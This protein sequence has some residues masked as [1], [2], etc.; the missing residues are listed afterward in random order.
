[1]AF[2]LLFD[3]IDPQLHG[4]DVNAFSSFGDA[5]VEITNNVYKHLGC[6]SFLFCPTGNFSLCYFDYKWF[7]WNSVFEYMPIVIGEKFHIICLCIVQFSLI[8][9]LTGVQV[10]I[11]TSFFLILAPMKYQTISL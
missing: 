10:Y 2:A 4:P 9:C 8:L 6:P 5:Q 11:L 3:D 1:M 7:L